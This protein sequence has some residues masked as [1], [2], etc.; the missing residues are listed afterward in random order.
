[1]WSYLNGGKSS[2]KL[3]VT[4]FESVMDSHTIRGCGGGGGGWG[5]GPLTSRPISSPLDK[6]WWGPTVASCTFNQKHACMLG[7]THT[8]IQTHSFPTELE[9]GA[10]PKVIKTRLLWWHRHHTNTNVPSHTSTHTLTHTRNCLFP[11]SSLSAHQHIRQV[12]PLPLVHR[13]KQKQSDRD[14][15]RQKGRQMR[16]AADGWSE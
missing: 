9:A 14:T 12:S 5:S 11:L 15:E 10:S 4:V 1:M 8:R 7:H 3:V 2:R 6:A 13:K 16:A